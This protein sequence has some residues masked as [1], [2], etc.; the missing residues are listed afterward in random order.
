MSYT[1]IDKRRALIDNMI[2]KRLSKRN[3]KRITPGMKQE[4]V[5]FRTVR[6][7][8]VLYYDGI[9]TGTTEAVQVALQEK[10]CNLL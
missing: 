1:I 8:I 6:P 10:L 7:E 2:A 5:F 3:Q 4:K 9:P